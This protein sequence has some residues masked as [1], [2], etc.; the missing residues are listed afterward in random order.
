MTHDEDMPTRMPD[1][2][3]APS[4]AGLSE[5][6]AKCFR[7]VLADFDVRVQTLNSAN[8]AAPSEGLL[9]TVSEL[10]IEVRIDLDAETG[11]IHLDASAIAVEKP[12]TRHVLAILCACG[13]VIEKMSIAA[14]MIKPRP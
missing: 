7:P 6:L 1:G 5:Q 12:A 8:I 11:A 9:L 4:L 3:T 2:R 10:A 13:E 14:R